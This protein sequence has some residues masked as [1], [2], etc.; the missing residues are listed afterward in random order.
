M[1][2]PLIKKRL[3]C[4]ACCQSQI[5]RVFNLGPTPLANAF[6]SAKQL[7]KEELFY[8][9][10]VYF[11]QNC[12][13]VQLGH[14]VDPRVLFSNYVYVSSTSPTFMKHFEDFAQVVYK[15][16]LLNKSSL[17]IDIGSNDGI[18][19]K[20]Y[21]K[22]ECRVLGIEPAKKIAAC[23]NKQGIKTIAQFFSRDLARNLSKKN[24]ADIITA[25]NV[26]AHIDDLDEVVYGI[27][28]LLKE[29]GVFIFE[30]AYLLDFMKKRY[31]DQ[32]YHEH[33]CY[34]SIKPLVVFF[35]RLGMEIFDVEKV[36]VQGGSI[37]V[38]VQRVKGK[39]PISKK[40]KH[41]IDLETQ[42]KLDKLE[43]YLEYNKKILDNKTK[44]IALLTDLK[45]KGKKIAA[46]GA[47][48]KG[49]TLLNYFGIGSDYLEY[50]VDD[51]TWKQGLFTPGKRIPVVKP[52]TIYQKKVDYLLILA[53][54]FAESIMG[55]HKRFKDEGG[56]F[57]I[58]V[59][60]PKIV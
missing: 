39:Y 29:D 46:Y 17:I 20:P 18:L 58:P 27:K 53:W 4:R 32:V 36:E 19:L 26:F 35:K 11:C 51:S 5:K 24:K 16:F 33:V 31:F 13:M 2:T 44:L 40:V 45:H 47:P 8:P 3:T 57:I 14:V 12:S 28:A 43:T 41:F 37:R 23:A 56:K 42:D 54:N 9:L 59:P 1:K 7:D 25:T 10:D 21:K 22:L 34:W 49:N 50:V 55:M 52:A 48:A 6:L 15:R 30:V 38:Y 60:Q